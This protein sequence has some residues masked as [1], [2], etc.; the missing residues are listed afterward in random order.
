MQAQSK[1]KKKKQ[2]Q[3]IAKNKDYHSLSEGEGSELLLWINDDPDLC[4]NPTQHW[5]GQGL[6]GHHNTQD[7][8]TIT[9]N[10]AHP[11][12]GT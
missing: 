1:K 7:T 5:W 11:V 8:T 2:E 10:Y 3:A 9:A 6:S 4:L 12:T